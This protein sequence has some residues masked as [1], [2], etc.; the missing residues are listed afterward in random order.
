MFCSGWEEA[1]G[2]RNRSGAQPQSCK[3]DPRLGEILLLYIMVLCLFFFFF[4]LTNYLF[5]HRDELGCCLVN[6]LQLIVPD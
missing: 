2:R 6:S 1:E 4:Q 3:S 5:T